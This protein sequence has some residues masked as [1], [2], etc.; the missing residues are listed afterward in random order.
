MAVARDAA[1]HAGTLYGRMFRALR[2]PVRAIEAEAEQLHGIE[3]AGERGETPFIAILGV[4]LFL[5]PIFLVMVGLAF[6]AYYLAR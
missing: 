3:Q 5:L 1:A 2:M 6:A 4:V